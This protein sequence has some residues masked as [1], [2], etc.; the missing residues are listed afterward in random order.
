MFC[1]RCR[2]E[3]RPGFAKCA[4]CGSKLVLVLAS[5][6]PQGES[7]KTRPQ[8]GE[9]D[10]VVILR[11]GDPFVVMT[12]KSVLDEGGLP[13]TVA[14][15]GPAENI[16]YGLQGLGYPGADPVI[17]CVRR[18]DERGARELVPP[19]IQLEAPSAGS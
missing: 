19:W 11:S 6:S 14:E 12:V 16:G 13:Y 17:I 1:P 5:P 7:S 3:Y 4:D 18:Q 9:P 15:R 2:T 8:P 10:V